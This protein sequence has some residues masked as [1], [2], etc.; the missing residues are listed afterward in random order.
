MYVY[1]YIYIYVNIYIYIHIYVYIH[2]Y[3][4]LIFVSFSVFPYTSIYRHIYRE[5]IMHV[6]GW[7]RCIRCHKLQVSF[8]KRAT[9]Y[10]ALLQKENDPERY[11]LQGG[12]TSSF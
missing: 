9:K 7:Q 2:T 12:D 6:T 3:E 5:P 8:H 1:T 10:K 4:S 11:T